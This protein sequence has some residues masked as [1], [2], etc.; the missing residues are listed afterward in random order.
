MGVMKRKEA[1]RMCACTHRFVYHQYEK[2]CLKVRKMQGAVYRCVC[3]E[4][5]Q[6]EGGKT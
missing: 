2:Q 5:R 1:M 6:H 4:F 3:K